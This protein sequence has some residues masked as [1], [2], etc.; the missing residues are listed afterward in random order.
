MIVTLRFFRSRLISISGFRETSLTI[1]TKIYSRLPF[2]NYP[3]TSNT[4]DCSYSTICRSQI[5]K[6]QLS[7]REKCQ[8]FEEVR[9]KHKFLSNTVSY[10]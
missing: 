7:L 8:Q 9:F 5:R 4:F 1:I 6:A 2:S 10:R 3:K